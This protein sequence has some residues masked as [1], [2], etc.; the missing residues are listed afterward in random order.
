MRALEVISAIIAETLIEMGVMILTEPPEIHWPNGSISQMSAPVRGKK[1]K[2]VQ[3][4]KHGI[5]GELVCS[6]APTLPITK[7]TGNNSQLKKAAQTS[8]GFKAPLKKKTNQSSEVI[9][10][11]ESPDLISQ[12]DV[13][14]DNN[15]VLGHQGLPVQGRRCKSCETINLIHI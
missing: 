7:S 13:Q 8:K 6:L 3:K 15:V 2:K 1:G 14:G 5:F 11:E 9:Q 4:T 10:V 12:D